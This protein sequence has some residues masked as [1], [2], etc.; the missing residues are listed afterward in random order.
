MKNILTEMK[1]NFQGINSRVDKA[2]DQIR[3]LEDKEAENTQSKQQ[4]A[5][6]IQKSANSIRSHW[7]NFNRTNICIMA[8]AVRRRES[9]RN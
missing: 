7:D 5:K 1:N 8:V 4:K 9:A 6:R 3:D 2:G